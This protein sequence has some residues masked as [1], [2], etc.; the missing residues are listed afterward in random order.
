MKELNAVQL[1]EVN[2][3]KSIVDSIIDTIND[4]FDCLG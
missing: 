4:V 3:G 2:G 1:E